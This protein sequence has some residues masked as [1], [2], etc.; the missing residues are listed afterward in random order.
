MLYY[1]LP[2]PF[3]D[4]VEEK[5]FTTIKRVMRKTGAR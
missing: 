1:G 3:R 4:D 5:I 2:G